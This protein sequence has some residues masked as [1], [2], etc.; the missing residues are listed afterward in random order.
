MNINGRFRKW[1]L[2]IVALLVVFGFAACGGGGGSA[3]GG[4]GG[5]G[6]AVGT[7]TDFGSIFVNGVEFHTGSATV[8]IDDS[9]GSESDLEL[10]MVVEIEGDFND[11]GTSGTAVTVNFN[12]VVEGPMTSAVDTTERSFDVMGQVVFYTATTV[13]ENTG[14]LGGGNIAPTDLDIHNVVE[15]SGLVDSAG[16]IKATRVERK[17]LV[18][19]GEILEVNGIVAAPLTTTNAVTGSF[20][21]N[22]L[23]VHYSV[24]TSFD[25]GT[26]TNL[27]IG[28]LV[29]VK[30]ND[31]PSDGLDA[32]R[33][34]FKAA[35]FGNNGDLLRFEGVVT[36]VAPST[37][38]F[39][40]NG[41]P[42]VTNGSTEWRGGYTGLGDVTLDDRV[43]VDGRIE[44][45]SGTPVLVAR[46]VELEIEEDVKVEGFIEAVDLTGQTLTMLGITFVYDGN[47]EFD[48][49]SGG[50]DPFV[51][52][53]ID[54]TAPSTDWLQVRGYIDSE[55]VIRTTEVDRD[56]DDADPSEIILQG[57]ASNVPASPP[58]DFTI[59]GVTI[60]VD[61]VMGIQY[62]L[63]DIGTDETTFFN[64]LTNGRVVKARGTYDGT[65]TI[66]PE[67]LDLQN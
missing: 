66:T 6:K 60:A 27:A 41:L 51:A 42:V 65:D 16:Q 18:F 56:N 43:E 11:D 26:A 32:D 5:T 61:G 33:I 30:G 48:D 12:D 49:K 47:T 53:D 36:N 63:E 28:A 39:E 46:E 62:E 14:L 55:G 38:D 4:I 17:A 3:G 22:A 9:P 2:L 23:E 1:S 52:S 15:V 13:F 10:G 25:N 50:V 19:G 58:G 44:D 31:D 37:G 35:D 67:E 20:F 24:A 57:P 59:L 8:N 34:E 54:A 64:N 40:V 29:E 21:I 45:Q 7:I